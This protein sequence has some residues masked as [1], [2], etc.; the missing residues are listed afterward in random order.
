MSISII[1]QLRAAIPDDVPDLALTNHLLPL[2]LPSQS[3]VYLADRPGIRYGVTSRGTHDMVRA[4]RVLLRQFLATKIPCQMGKRAVS[5][6]ELPES[7]TVRFED[8]TSATGNILVCADGTNSAL[9]GQLLGRELK[10]Q[11]LPV[12]SIGGEV[13]LSG[14]DFENKLRLG[15]SSRSNFFSEPAEPGLPVVHIFCALKR[16]LPDGHSGEYYWFTIWVDDNVADPAHWTKTASQRESHDFVIRTTRGMEPRV[17]NI[18]DLTPVNKLLGDPFPQRALMLTDLPIGRVTLLG[19]AAHCMPPTRG[20][21]GVH[22]MMDALKLAECIGNINAVN[23]HDGSSTKSAVSIYQEE[24]L[25]RSQATVRK[26]V[27]A[28]S[29][30]LSSMG[31][32]GRDVQPLEWESISLEEIGRVQVAPA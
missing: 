13:T 11:L 31:W 5:F 2:D 1:P 29:L 24:M 12:A 26:N 19:D 3:V 22:A 16:V 4:D 25:R 15:H 27:D 7:V 28:S 9:R 21:A 17:L 8:G 18:I 20:E 30:N 14:K 23:D 10:P 6:E 32:G